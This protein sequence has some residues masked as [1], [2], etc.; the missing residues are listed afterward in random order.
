MHEDVE[1]ERISAVSQ[2]RGEATREALIAAALEFI[3]AGREFAFTTDEVLAAAG[4]T[5]G[6]L[7]Y[8]FGSRQ[9][10]IDAAHLRRIVETVDRDLTGIEAAAKKAKGPEEFLKQLSTTIASTQSR[11]RAG[12]RL[13]RARLMGQLSKGRTADDLADLQH[14]I[15]QRWTLLIARGQ[16]QGLITTRHSAATLAI[17]AQGITLGLIFDDVDPVQIDGTQ[18]RALVEDVLRRAF[19]P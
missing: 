18:W 8:H 2:P 9:G 3:D 19:L 12:Y 10:L 7:Y 17:L 13:D 11:E 1:G 4:A 15:N 16:K 5:N 6:S 14:T